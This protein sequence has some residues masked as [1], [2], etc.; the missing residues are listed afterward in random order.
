MFKFQSVSKSSNG[1]IRI[2]SR[3]VIFTWIAFRWYYTN[4]SQCNNIIIWLPHLYR[5]M[6]F[7]WANIKYLSWLDC[8]IIYLLPAIYWYSLVNI[9]YIMVKTQ[10]QYLSF[11]HYYFFWSKCNFVQQKVQFNLTHIIV[12]TPISD[13]LSG[14]Q[15]QET[16]MR[17]ADRISIYWNLIFIPAELTRQN[18]K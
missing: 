9:F 2:A 16:I 11:E 7:L 3:N 15:F 5:L 4:S 18:N 6:L 14:S 17:A 13:G 12:F 1:C 8:I 10:N